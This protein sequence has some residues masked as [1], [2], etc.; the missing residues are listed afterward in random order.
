[1]AREKLFRNQ[2]GE[3]LY[4]FNWKDEDE[5]TCGFNDIWAPN[6][7]EAVK[8]VK[9]H[10]TKAHWSLYDETLRTYV[11]VPKEVFG[12]S[13]CFRMKGMYADPTSMRRC[14]YSEYESQNRAGWMMSI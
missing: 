4:L 13:H 1:M 5:N 3:Y 9:S 8:R 14:K 6:K 12:E 2:E 10:E 7:R 11:T